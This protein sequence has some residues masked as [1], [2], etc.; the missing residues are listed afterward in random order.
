MHFIAKSSSLQSRLRQV[1]LQGTSNLGRDSSSVEDFD[2]VTVWVLQEQFL[3]NLN[4]TTKADEAYLDEGKS[5]HATVIWFLH[6]R[7]AE[8]L[9]SLASHIDVRHHKPNV[10]KSPRV[11]VAV[12]IDFAF[13]VLGAPIVCQLDSCL[14]RHRPDLSS[15]GLSWD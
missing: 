7:H 5:L 14:A 12:M 15:V 8:L 10:T 13:L 2:P 9:E 3:I 6:E 11:R 1:E 4:S